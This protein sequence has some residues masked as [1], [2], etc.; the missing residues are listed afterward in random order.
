M[1]V[2]LDRPQESSPKYFKVQSVESHNVLF[3]AAVSPVE[4]VNNSEPFLGTRD[5]EVA[6]ESSSMLTLQMEKIHEFTKY[7]FTKNNI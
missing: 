7:I 6:V 3:E 4:F 5:S 1:L 2:S